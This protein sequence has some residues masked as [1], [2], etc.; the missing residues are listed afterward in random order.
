[1]EDQ[2]NNATVTQPE[3]TPPVQ[4]APP[5]V[6]GEPPVD[7]LVLGTIE[8]QEQSAIIALQKQHQN[9]V[10]QIGNAELRK[11][12]MM[13]QIQATEDRLQNV[14][15]NIGKRLNIPSQKSWTLMADGKIREVVQ[16]AR[17]TLVPKE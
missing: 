3:V 7:P 15:A 9:L 12:E 10:F 6:A 14:Y 2:F 11:F 4:D 17:P 5:E 13:V 1:M 8:P 16:P